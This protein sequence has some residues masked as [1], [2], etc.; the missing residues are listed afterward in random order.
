MGKP[1]VRNSSLIVGVIQWW[2][3]GSS[4]TGVGS[5]FLRFLAAIREF[6]CDFAPQRRRHRYGDVDYDWDHRVDTTSATVSWRDRLLG[7]LNSPYQ[8]TE[9][10]LFREMLASFNIDFRDFTFIDIGS[11]KGRILLMASSYPFRRILGIELLAGLHE[12]AKQNITA[13]KD[14]S[15]VCSALE[16]ICL[17]ARE[18][19][20]PVEPLLLYLFNPLPARGLVHVLDNLEESLRINP[21]RIY[22]LYHNPEHQ[23][24]LT[25]SKFLRKIGGTHQYS[26]FSNDLVP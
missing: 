14:D 23:L 2:R 6:A 20:F 7:V 16:S 18:F 25:Q 26:I 24:L 4:R 13:Y 8:P 15:Q 10:G 11:G 5:T 22:M 12:V 21:R 9:E 3:E 17:D 19:I 1:Q